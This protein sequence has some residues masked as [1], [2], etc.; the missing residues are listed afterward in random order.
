MREQGLKKATEYWQAVR[1]FGLPFGV[2][3]ICLNYMDFRITNPGL[4]YSWGLHIVD[5]VLMALFVSALWWLLVS[6]RKAH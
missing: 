1:R 4:H 5:A 2:V 3:F 6:K